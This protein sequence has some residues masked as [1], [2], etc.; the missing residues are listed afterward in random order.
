MNLKYWVRKQEVFWLS[1]MK[2]RKIG[3]KKNKNTHK[4]MWK[5]LDEKNHEEKNNLLCQKLVQNGRVSSGYN[6]N[7]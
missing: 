7:P 6:I 3:N 2:K 1:V 4:F 5:T